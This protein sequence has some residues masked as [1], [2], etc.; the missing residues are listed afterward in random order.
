VTSLTTATFDR[1]VKETPR[2]FVEFYAPWCSHC[3]KLAPVWKEVAERLEDDSSVVVASVDGTTDRSLLARFNVTG[4]PT[5]KLFVDGVRVY[6]YT[7]ERSASAMVGYVANGDF[8]VHKFT[9]MP[10]VPT[11]AQQLMF[12]LEDGVGLAEKQV[13]NAVKSFDAGRFDDP[14]YLWVAAIAIVLFVVGLVIPLTL[15]TVIGAVASRLR[16]PRPAPARVSVQSSSSTTTATKPPASDGTDPPKAEA[17]PKPE[18]K[19]DQ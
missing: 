17:A 5:I 11:F 18:T 10:S 14:A 12:A 4:F 7:G 8:G 6:T 2:V 13:M 1:V 16:A 9:I 15:R 3:T 19:K